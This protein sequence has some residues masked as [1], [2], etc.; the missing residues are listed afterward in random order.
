MQSCTTY[1]TLQLGSANS[2]L[3]SWTPRS[4]PSLFSSALRC[5]KMRWVLQAVALGATLLEACGKWG[6]L[7]ATP[8]LRPGAKMTGRHFTT[9]WLGTRLGGLQI[10]KAIGSLP[11]LY[12]MLWDVFGLRAQKNNIIYINK[13]RHLLSKC[14]VTKQVHLVPRICIDSR[15][16]CPTI[17]CAVPLW[18]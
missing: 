9:A 13:M 6:A 5:F 12:L 16:F 14:F 4:C 8:T 18:C 1:R 7:S 11:P 17:V 10:L 2:K 15:R 3:Q